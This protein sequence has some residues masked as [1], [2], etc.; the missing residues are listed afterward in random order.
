MTAQGRIKTT[1][2]VVAK[3]PPRT[4]K[5]A[6]RAQPE[7][8]AG[9]DTETREEIGDDGRFAQGADDHRPPSTIVRFLGNQHRGEKHALGF[10]RLAGVAHFQL[11][12]I[13]V[14]APHDLFE[15]VDD[16]AGVLGVA[17]HVEPK[18]HVRRANV[19]FAVLRRSCPLHADDDAIQ[20]SY[21]YLGVARRGSLFHSVKLMSI[22]F[23]TIRLLSGVR[24]RRATTRLN[25]KRRS[26]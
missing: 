17:A 14:V 6:D 5:R 10:V 23:A 20:L 1:P 21:K 4:E 24:D 26:G 16:A 7:L 8:R 2:R 13:W 11:Q 15:R 12:F 25:R 3:G 22:N 9:M 19:G 18:P